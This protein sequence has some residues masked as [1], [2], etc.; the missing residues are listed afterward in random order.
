MGT[1]TT[2]R[3]SEPAKKSLRARTFGL[4]SS[5]PP[6]QCGLATFSTALGKSLVRQGAA[7]GVVRVLD[8]PEAYSA[9]DLPLIGELMASDP[10]SSNRVVRALN[11]CDAVF[12]QHEYGLYGGR[13][14]SDI[15]EVLERVH[16]PVIATL[17]T[18]LAAPTA[19][20][21]WVLNEVL[22]IA[23]AVIV[24]TD[25]AEV[26]LR[27][28]YDVGATTVSMIPHGAAVGPPSTPIAHGARPT[29]LTWGLIG[30]G[31]G[32]Q[33]VIDALVS[34]RDL[35][36][37][38]LYVVAGQTHPKVLAR[39][40]DAYRE[41]LVE[42]VARN[43]VGDLVEFDNSYR[44][45]SSLTD[46]IASADAVILPYDSKDQA[47]SGVLVD[48][49]AAGKPVIATAF[50]HAIELLSDGAGIVIAQGDVA[51]LSEAMR[52][53]ASNPAA[54]AEMS[55]RAAQLAPGLSWDAVGRQYRGVAARLLDRVKIVA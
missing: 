22:R 13:D 23:D 48:A 52:R 33:W 50:P 45:L 34:L 10:S 47:T 31:K 55:A 41:S 30:P 51:A 19:N 42:R 29:F 36:P 5:A 49:V 26:I 6:T 12:V 54:T 17:H 32:I 37:A 43:D 44:D 35:D 24:M 1:L 7:V 3:G 21:R 25:G 27:S 11:R 2:S 14:G 39:E 8:A 16:V 20:Q 4:L 46:L 18:V 15:L 9:T 53:V 28:T 40:G 38:P